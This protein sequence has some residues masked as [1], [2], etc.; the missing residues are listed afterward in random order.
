LVRIVLLPA[1]LVTLGPWAEGDRT[2]E[3]EETI[4]AIKKMKGFVEFDT[5]RL[6]KPVTKV[7]LFAGKT[8][9]IGL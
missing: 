5:Q 3:Q 9:G 8:A 4:A 2:A 6:D 7:H 1:V